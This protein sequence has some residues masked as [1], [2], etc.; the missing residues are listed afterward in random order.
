M[1]FKIHF[2]CGWCMRQDIIE[3]IIPYDP[4]T[5]EFTPNIIY[6]GCK[7]CKRLLRA[8]LEIWGLAV[9]VEND[10]QVYFENV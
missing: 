3:H 5:G 4:S 8:D 2:S 9:F 6:I 10:L 7:Q 1:E